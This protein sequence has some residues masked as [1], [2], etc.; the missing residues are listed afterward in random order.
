[1]LLELIMKLSGL[2]TDESD[3]KIGHTY[4]IFSSVCIIICIIH[5]VFIYIYVY[6]YIYIY[7]LLLLFNLAES[8]H[9]I[10]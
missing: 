10:K 5:N 7:I 8:F 1:M 9:P 3:S 6:I 2:Q 4:T